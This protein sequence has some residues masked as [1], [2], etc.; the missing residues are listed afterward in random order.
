[1]S[2]KT[3]IEWTDASWNPSRGCTRASP[4]CMHCY[5]EIQAARIITMDRGKNIPEGRGSYDG[6]LAKGG[7]WNGTVAFVPEILDAPLRW[8]R[9][10]KIFVN[11]MSD[12]FHESL[13]VS[14]IDK[15]FAVMALS[16]ATSN[17]PHI[18]QILTKRSDIMLR[19][20]K[21]PALMARIQGEAKVLRPGVELHLESMWPLP[22]L[23]LGVSVE[24]Q[25]YTSRITNLL[26]APATVRWVSLE[27]LIGPINLLRVQ[28]GAHTYNALSK[29]EGIG[30]RGVG[31]DWV[32]VGGESGDLARPMHPHWAESLR[33]QCAQTN[34]PF[35]FKQWGSWCPRGP[36]SL[37]HPVVDRVPV[38]CVTE[39]GAERAQ[40][41]EGDPGKDVWM[42]R[43]GKKRSGRSLNGVIYD[44][45]PLA[46]ASIQ[47]AP[48]L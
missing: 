20:L 13:D 32:V 3:N 5:A 10:R 43:A 45:Y 4:G 19:Y 17:E 26:D 36:A 40:T 30:Y 37:G 29:R 48:Q 25:A 46:L 47:K 9:Q 8:K 22:N 18:F 23:W 28:D 1:M 44:D 35:L 34:V 33:Q 7:Q 41:S 21:D 39:L 2:R 11:S 27:P 42:N 31:L 24:S 14:V 15:I 12:V 38:M 16:Y 6:L